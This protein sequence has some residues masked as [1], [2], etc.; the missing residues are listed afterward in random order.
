M[1][2]RLSIHSILISV[3]FFSDKMRL[4]AE[5]DWP[6][7]QN[8]LHLFIH[9]I[10]NILTGLNSLLRTGFDNQI[11]ILHSTCNG[12]M[13]K[14]SGVMS[15]VKL[16]M[17]TANERTPTYTRKRANFCQMP[18][19]CRLYHAELKRKKTDFAQQVT[20]REST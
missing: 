17:I 5:I 9:R 4:R 16:L 2:L 12:V 6:P 18:P 19:H 11:L 7:I 3:F 1:T 13:I 20:E 14:A 10:D 15:Q 8:L